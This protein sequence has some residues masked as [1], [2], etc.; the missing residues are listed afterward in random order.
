[1]NRTKSIDGEE[2]CVYKQAIRT[3]EDGRENASIDLERN[4]NKQSCQ[5]AEI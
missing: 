5:M 2:L 1:M 4:Y 3:Q